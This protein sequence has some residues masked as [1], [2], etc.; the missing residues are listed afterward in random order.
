MNKWL[1]WAVL[2][3]TVGGGLVGLV[4][5]VG[6]IKFDSVLHAIFPPFC[7]ALY[8]FVIF[9]GLAFARDVNRIGPLQVALWLQVPWIVTPVFIYKFT[10][11]LHA[12][13][14]LGTPEDGTFGL[15]MGGAAW[16]G[17]VCKLGYGAES[18]TFGVNLIA[19]AL[20][21][22]LRQWKNRDKLV[23][24]SPPALPADVVEP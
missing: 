12:V 22:Y 9:S 17:A 4:I 14:S 7:I 19:L 13:V 6:E 23:N 5:S 24:V 1:Y 3:V 2:L 18:W 10:A 15:R 16:L 20:L 21:F 11:G 8:A